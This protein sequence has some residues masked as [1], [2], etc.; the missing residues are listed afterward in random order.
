MREPVWEVIHD[1]SKSWRTKLIGDLSSAY[2]MPR[3]VELFER[4]L[5]SPEKKSFLEIGSGNGEIAERIRDKKF[6]FISRYLVSENF[7]KGVEW[8]R[9]KGFE[10]ELVDAQRIPFANA[11]FDAVLCFDVMHHVPDPA[12]MGRE[13]MRVGRG[14][15]FLTESNG[16]SLGRKLMEWTSGHRKAGER[17]Y[18]PAQYRSFFE[19]AGFRVLHFEIHPFVFPLRLPP[20]FSKWQVAFNR[21]IERVPVLKWQCSNTYLYLEYERIPEDPKR[22]W[23]SVYASGA[24]R[25]KRKKTHREKLKKM[26][27]FK[28][29]RFCRIL[30]VACG[31][32]EMLDLMAEEGFSNLTGLDPFDRAEKKEKS[33]RFVRGSSGQLPF[34]AGDFDVILC[35]HALHHFSGVDEIRSFFSEAARVLAPGGRLYVVDHYDSRQLSLACFFLRSPLAKMG[36]WMSEFRDQLYSERAELA[37]YL[38]HYREVR[39]LVE[40][41]PFPVKKWKKDCFFFY[42]EGQKAP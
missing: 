21:W 33:W 15:L 31:E 2:V 39:D 12:V 4:Y 29:P 1:P 41:A 42:F 37:Y 28:L 10:A 9:Q 16:L 22:S 18:T 7:K 36:K 25:K 27:L 30:D 38:K 32:G 34:R 6:D 26:G 5:R 40:K 20:L 11:S 14:R 3:Y 13:M 17:S 35:A 19:H 23:H 8:L 24:L